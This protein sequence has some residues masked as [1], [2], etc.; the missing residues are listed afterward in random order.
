MVVSYLAC[1]SQPLAADSAG[2]LSV[3][4][5]SEVSEKVKI[6]NLLE[7]PLTLGPPIDV[8]QK[9]SMGKN[10][11]HKI[12][13]TVLKSSHLHH[14]GNPMGSNSILREPI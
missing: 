5:R 2:A 3:R 10:L 9:L 7:Q 4:G 1:I 13:E 14:D 8:A 12:R 6:R 11:S